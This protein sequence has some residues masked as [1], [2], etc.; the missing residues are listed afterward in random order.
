MRT[1]EY[2]NIALHGQSSGISMSGKITIKLNMYAARA[3]FNEPYNKKFS[4]FNILIK[5]YL[6]YNYFTN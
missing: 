1:V 2:Y 3:F 4:I 6:K 5:E